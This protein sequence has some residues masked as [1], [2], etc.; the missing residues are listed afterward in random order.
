MRTREEIKADLNEV[1]PWK[2]Q[3]EVLLDIRDILKEAADH[4]KQL[5]IARQIVE[6]LMAE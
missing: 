3:L 5:E 4:D 1:T 6:E 2:L